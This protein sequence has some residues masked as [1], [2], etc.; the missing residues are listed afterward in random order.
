MQQS[1]STIVNQNCSMARWNQRY[2][3]L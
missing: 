1:S 3:Y 2:H